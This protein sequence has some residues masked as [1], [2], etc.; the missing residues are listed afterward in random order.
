M[1][2]VK[3]QYSPETIS[4]AK[5]ADIELNSKKLLIREIMELKDLRDKLHVNHEALCREYN[6]KDQT[7]QYLFQEIEAQALKKTR[8]MNEI[9]EEKKSEYEYIEKQTKKVDEASVVLNGL[10][11]EEVAKT[12][13]LKDEIGKIYEEREQFTRENARLQ[14][15]ADQVE[16][17]D[18]NI[19]LDMLRRERELKESKEEFELYKASMEKDF[20]KINRIKNENA[21][22]LEKINRTEEKIEKERNSMNHEI[23]A[24]EAEIKTERDTYLSKEN[25]VALRHELLDK[26]EQDLKDTELELRAREVEAQKVLT[27]QQAQ[28]VIDAG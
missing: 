23:A 24:K 13:Q 4:L 5:R 8:I 21:T 20:A 18:K 9:K 10:K 15:H 3:Q 26:R 16:A 12:K 14:R 22:L 17:A 27:R 2:S 28:K 19:K 1:K 25:S 7:L 11:N 6:A